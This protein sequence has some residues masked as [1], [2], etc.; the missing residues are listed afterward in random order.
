MAKGR[1]KWIF[2][3]VFNVYIVIAST[4]VAKSKSKKY[5]LPTWSSMIKTTFTTSHSSY[6][7][8]Y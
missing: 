6:P 3:S 5:I 2:N 4:D 1:K 7:D 8:R